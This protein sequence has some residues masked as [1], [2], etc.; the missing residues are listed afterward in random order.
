MD[1]IKE[2]IMGNDSIINKLLYMDDEE[3]DDL[4]WEEINKNKKKH[5]KKPKRFDSM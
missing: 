4:V 3:V 1:L 5:K 2:I